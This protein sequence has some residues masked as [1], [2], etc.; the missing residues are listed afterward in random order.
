MPVRTLSRIVSSCRI[1]WNS[2]CVSTASRSLLVAVMVAFRG[3]GSK[4]ASSPKKSPLL[5]VA[6]SSPP[7]VTRAVPSR[8]TK[9][10][11]PRSPSRM[12]ASPAGTSLMRVTRATRMSSSREH[13]LKMGTLEK[14][15][16]T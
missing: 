5:R 2:G 3:A 1:S 8:I 12:T 4:R 7:R 13:A 6:T 11:R 14:L 10:S 16:S 15:V 9:N